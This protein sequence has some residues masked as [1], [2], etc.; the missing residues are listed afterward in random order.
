MQERK[1]GKLLLKVG[2]VLRQGFPSTVSRHSFLCHD[3]VLKAGTRPGLGVCAHATAAC[4]RATKLAS[5]VFLARVATW[6]SDRLGNLGHDRG[7]LYCDKV[8]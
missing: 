7:F 2:F 8:L 3:M 5:L 1:K 6:S 4:A